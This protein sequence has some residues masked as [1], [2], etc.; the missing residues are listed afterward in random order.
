MGNPKYG[1]LQP[2]VKDFCEVTAQR[3]D[4]E[5]EAE[6]YTALV[7]SSEKI[8]PS[9]GQVDRLLVEAYLAGVKRERTR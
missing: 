5:K 4:D 6:E 7:D 9:M 1:Q 3:F 8:V 2:S